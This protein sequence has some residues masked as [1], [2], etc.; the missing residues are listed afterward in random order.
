M[1]LLA[2]HV[3]IASVSVAISRFGWFDTF[4]WVI[5]SKAKQ[6]NGME[7]FMI[8]GFLACCLPRSPNGLARN[9]EMFRLAPQHDKGKIC[10]RYF[11][12]LR[13]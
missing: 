9:D 13:A 7:S 8:L 2:S 10:M 4:V 12:S 6:S 1:R 3:G 5:A 11:L